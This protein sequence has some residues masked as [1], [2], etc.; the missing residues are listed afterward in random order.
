MSFD[1]QCTPLAKKEH[2]CEWCEVKIKVGERYYYRCGFY[3]DFYTMQMHQECYE[4]YHKERNIVDDPWNECCVDD[5]KDHYENR[6][7][8]EKIK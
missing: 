1:R 5:I 4:V 6:L 3:E 8:E 2:N 7:L